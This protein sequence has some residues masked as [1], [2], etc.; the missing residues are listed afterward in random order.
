MK[1]KKNINFGNYSK[2]INKRRSFI[3]GIKGPHLKKKE[4]NFLRT[5]KP[6]G[7]I[8]FKRNI[9]DIKQTIKLTKQIKNIFEDP[10]YP[11]LVDEEGGRVSRLTNIIDNSLFSSDFFG[12]IYDYNK[13]KLNYYLEVYINQISYLSFLHFHL[14]FAILNL[15]DHHLQH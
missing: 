8:L 2:Q 12:K 11:I 15:H 9:K 3:C 14:Q 4:I 13:N 6:W 1:I 7:I 10:Y 5:Y